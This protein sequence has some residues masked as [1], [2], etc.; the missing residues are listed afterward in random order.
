MDPLIKRYFE[1]RT[2]GTCGGF[3][4]SGKLVLLVQSLNHIAVRVQC[5]CCDRLIGTAIIS[6]TFAG[7]GTLT[8]KDRKP[9]GPP[10]I[11]M[12]DVLDFSRFINSD[13]ALKNLAKAKHRK[14]KH[15]NDR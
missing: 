1:Q 14:Q 8:W 4:G 10:P 13:A 9:A 2:C 3:I 15:A 6:G 7:A 12:D 5:S 11:T